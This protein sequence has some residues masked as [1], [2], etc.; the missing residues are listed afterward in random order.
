MHL[1][2]CTA[3]A[4]KVY[5]LYVKIKN[6]VIFL[7]WVSLLKLPGKVNIFFI[8]ATSMCKANKVA[9][10]IAFIQIQEFLAHFF[11][12]K[13]IVNDLKLNFFLNFTS[14]SYTIFEKLYFEKCCLR[15]AS[16][17]FRFTPGGS[18]LFVQSFSS[19]HALG[20]F[21]DA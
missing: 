20:L 15:S 1:F 5:K 12:I 21:Q 4:L 7:L 2:G 14:L 11:L 8:E 10:A 6:Y 16:S 17:V 18:D 9:S 13:L 3:L 19:Y